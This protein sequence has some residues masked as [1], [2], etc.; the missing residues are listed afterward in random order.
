MTPTTVYLVQERKIPSAV[1]YPI[2]AV[3]IASTLGLAAWIQP[4]SALPWLNLLASF[5]ILCSAAYSTYQQRTW[6]LPRIEDHGAKLSIK[7]ARFGPP[8]DVPADE[9]RQIRINPRQALIDWTEEQSD[10]RL[11]IPL[12]TYDRYKATQ[13][14][15]QRFAEANEVTIEGA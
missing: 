7:P 14:L 2:L 6:G 13:Q 4:K 1:W 9:I 12:K 11:R 5:L 3:L 8:T 10:R 15:L